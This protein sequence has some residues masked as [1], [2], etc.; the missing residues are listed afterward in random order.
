[1][2]AAARSKNLRYDK[3]GEEHYNL[4]SALIKSL[5]G[6]DPDAALYWAIRM[7]EGAKTRASCCAG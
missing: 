6:S 3:S 5:R 7:I 2:E 1:V 4:A